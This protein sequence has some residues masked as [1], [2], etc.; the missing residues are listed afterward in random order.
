MP[1]FQLQLHDGSSKVVVAGRALSDENG[2]CLEQLVDG[3]W[4]CVYAVS[5]DDVDRFQRRVT[6]PN[7][8]WTWILARPKPASIVRDPAGSATL[9]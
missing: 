4:K 7:G 6:E 1:T 2:L 3:R 9:R 5:H 8:S